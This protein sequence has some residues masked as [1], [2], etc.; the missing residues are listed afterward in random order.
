MQ[1]D[2]K[3]NNLKT[4]EAFF[5]ALEQHDRDALSPLLSDAVVEVIPLSLTGGL[6]PASVFNGKSAVL[7]YLGTIIDN[8]SRAALTDKISHVTDDGQTVFLE[9]RGDL[10]TKGTS[11]PYN[12]I[13]VFKF[14]FEDGMIIHISEYANPITFAKAMSL[15]FG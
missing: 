12:N 15:P 8:F 7:G 14:V 11:Q 6:E 2:T 1:T 13:Y 10:L 5:V 9:A 3:F 4:A